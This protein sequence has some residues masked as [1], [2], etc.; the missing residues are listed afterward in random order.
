M[1]LFFPLILSGDLKVGGSEPGHP[2]EGA[3]AVR[4]KGQEASAHQQRH[5]VNILGAG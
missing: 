3:G 5:Y 2:G 4:A 1:S